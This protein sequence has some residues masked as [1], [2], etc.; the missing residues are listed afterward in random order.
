MI[1]RLDMDK[2]HFQYVDKLFLEVENTELLRIGG[3]DI[4]TGLFC[5]STGCPV[6]P[7]TS[8]AGSVR[9]YFIENKGL[10]E[11]FGYLFGG[12]LEEQNE[13]F[14]DSKVYFY[15][16]PMEEY[17]EKNLNE[18]LEKR[19]ENRHDA[20]RGGAKDKALHEM[21]YLKK[22]LKFHIQIDC[23][24]YDEREH[25]T[26]K[27]LFQEILNGICSGDIRFG[28]R[29]NSG[30]GRVRTVKNSRL[31]YDLSKKKDFIDYALGVEREEKKKSYAIVF[32]NSLSNTIK[33]V[34]E[35]DIK[36]ALLIK[37]ETQ[38]EQ[39]QEDS[40]DELL[41]I[42]D[43]VK[44][45]EDSVKERNI[46]CSMKSG[47]NFIIPGTTIKGILRGYSDKIVNTLGYSNAIIAKMF[48]SS[49]DEEEQHSAGRIQTNDCVIEVDEKAQ[50]YGLV[51]HRIKIDRFT[52]GAMDGAL[53][54]EKPVTKGK[55]KMEI[56]FRKLE[57]EEENQIIFVLLYLCLRDIG[58]GKV[59]FG[60]NA[61]IGFGRLR[62]KNLYVEKD[63]KK[64]NIQFD[65]LRADEWL[66]TELEKGFKKLK[67]EPK[68]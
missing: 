11:K 55:V 57:E 58:L 10:R 1:I 13:F 45:H 51:Y 2:N 31:S 18:Y 35:A 56:T 67:E 33:M 25:N 52:G 19:I 61:G 3:D 65:S 47:D 64:G 8:I 38:K 23:V 48:G 22:G 12:K 42:P 30:C 41:E 4:L 24:S 43:L 26:V 44:M 9:S 49:P 39:L 34:L 50:E 68:K 59:P 66:K 54:S 60:S 28:G 62:G 32:N 20:V 46:A 16:S 7:G 63:G 53:V 14:Y 36:D 29:K 17:T 21:I 6:I 5:D 37:T 15:D 40:Q 27:E